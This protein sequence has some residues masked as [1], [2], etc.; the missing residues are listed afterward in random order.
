MIKSQTISKTHNSPSP[1]PNEDRILVNHSHV[2][3]L[4]DGAGGTGILCGEWAEFLLKHLPDA[5]IHTFEEFITW[6]EPQTEAFVQQYEPLMQQD[7]FQLKDKATLLTGSANYTYNGFHK[8]SESIMLTDNQE[9]ICTS[10]GRFN[11]S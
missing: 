1:L 9:A 8:N 3:A 2:W 4:A 7:V 5:P 6:L 10:N 11:Y